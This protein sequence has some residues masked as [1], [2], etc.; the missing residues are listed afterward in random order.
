MQT[1]TTHELV[2]FSV[3]KHFDRLEGAPM[4]E[5]YSLTIGGEYTENPLTLEDLEE[6][7]SCLGEVIR[8][9]RRATECPSN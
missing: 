7:H 8:R 5:S 6:I 4:T 9:E 3:Q 2:L 1:E